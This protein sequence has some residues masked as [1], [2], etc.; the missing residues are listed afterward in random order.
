MY[1]RSRYGG[2]QLPHQ[3]I[4]PRD[5]SQEVPPSAVD[6]PTEATP[7][8]FPFFGIGASASQQPYMQMRDYPA[9][10]KQFSGSWENHKVDKNV[11]DVGWPVGADDVAKVPRIR[12]VPLK[13][14]NSGRWKALT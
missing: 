9:T 14:N 13:L 5:P 2:Q 6:I 8:H 11:E 12:V 3:W 4:Q 7:P 1:Q 10:F